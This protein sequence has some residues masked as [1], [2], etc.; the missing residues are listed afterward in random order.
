MGRFASKSSKT[1]REHRSIIKV[2]PYELPEKAL[3]VIANICS[4]KDN[5]DLEIVTQGLKKSLKIKDEKGYDWWEFCDSYGDDLLDEN[6][7]DTL[8]DKVSDLLY[9]LQIHENTSDTQVV[10]AGG[11]SAGK[12]SFLNTLVGAP[13]LLPTGIEPC[14][15]VPTYLY[16]SQ[17]IK[18]VGVK[19]VNLNNAVVRLDKDILQSIQHESQSKV[20]LASVLEKLFVELPSRDLDGFVFIDTPGY[21]NSE[22]VNAE[23]GKTDEDVALSAL[24]RGNV[25]LWVVDAGSGTVCTRDRQVIES[26]LQKNEN[27]QVVI[28]FNKADKKGR[29]EM[30]KIVGQTASQFASFGQQL[31]DVLGYS[32]MENQIYCS[33]KGFTLPALLKQIRT[34]CGNGKSEVESILIQIEQLFR[35]EVEYAKKGLSNYEDARKEY[36]ELKNNIYKAL[37]D[38]KEFIELV[39]DGFKDVAVKGYSQMMKVADQ[40]LIGWSDSL[41]TWTDFHNKVNEIEGGRIF[42][43]DR[44]G[45]L[46]NSDTHEIDRYNKKY[47]KVSD[48]TYYKE[49]YCKNLYSS[50]KDLTDFVERKHQNDYDECEND[51]KE[52]NEAIETHRYLVKMMNNYRMVVMNELGDG[53]RKYQQTAHQAQDVRI[54]MNDSQNVFAAIAKRDYKAFTACFSQGV[55]LNAHSGDGYSPLTYA[56]KEGNVQMV[57]FFIEQGADLSAYDGRG[58]NAFHTAVENGYR[59]LCEL[60]LEEDDS[61]IYSRT[62]QG[63]NVVEVYRPND[64]TNWLCNKI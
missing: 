31:I 4:K 1:A 44:L 18:E 58:M 42:G 27:R 24:D 34:R 41:S 53:I 54:S 28:L 60:M 20:Y 47:D 3:E 36:L 8:A 17:K 48:Y 33:S 22:K 51:L 40:A 61:L 45:Q 63:K 13:N 7:V 14:S 11:F 43:S 56:V 15:M 25:L 26:Y 12:S 30:Q 16:C 46:I 52:N 2:N 57:R 6:I 32:S 9:E 23:N 21:N 19:G 29:E 37:K 35:D 5:A 39:L 10:V 59:H 64:F 38:D 62:E 49:E 50:V 55:N